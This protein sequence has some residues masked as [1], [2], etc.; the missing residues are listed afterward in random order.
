MTDSVETIVRQTAAD[1]FNLPLAHVTAAT[2]PANV[3]GWDSVQQL[4]FVLALEEALRVQL[5]PEEVERIRS[6]GDAIAILKNKSK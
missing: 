3:E 5:E 6:V 2:S 4:N 1:V